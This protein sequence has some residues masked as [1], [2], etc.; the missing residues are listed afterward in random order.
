MFPIA[1]LLLP[2]SVPHAA[3]LNITQNQLPVN[4]GPYLDYFE[5]PEQA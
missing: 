4:L 1:L 5:D 3:E 2:V